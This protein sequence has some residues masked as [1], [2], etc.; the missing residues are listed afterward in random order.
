MYLRSVNFPSGIFTVTD[1]N[2]E[3]L[4]SFTLSLHKILN[5]ST[6]YCTVF[7]CTTLTVKEQKQRNNQGTS[8]L[9]T[10]C[11]TCFPVL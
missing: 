7:K 5:F 4:A 6:T 10:A 8:F 9:K 1:L 3:T 2:I 11:D